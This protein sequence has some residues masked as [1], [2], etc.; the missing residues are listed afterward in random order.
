MNRILLAVAMLVVPTTAVGTV[1]V[2]VTSSSSPY[3]LED[4]GNA[5]TPTVSTV[6]ADGTNVNGFD[7]WADAD[8]TIPGLLR[9]GSFPPSDSPTGTEANPIAIQPGSF[10]YV[11]L[12]FQNEPAGEKINGLP[13]EIRALGTTEPAA[14]TT[15]WYL[16]NNMSNIVGTKRWDGTAT[17]PDYPEFT[18]N[19]QT[20]VAITA[21]GIGNLAAADPAL[22]YGGAVDGRIALLGAIHAP[23][24]GTTYAVHLPQICYFI[25]GYATPMVGGDFQFVPEPGTCLLLALAAAGLGKRHRG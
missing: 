6:Y 12:Q 5:F 1:R 9:P 15:T 24:D 4:N 14:V 18:G 20:F 13:V 21:D 23:A 8:G 11:W 7:Y 3:G 17:P 2:F 19:P 16:C 22:L 10:A 25:V